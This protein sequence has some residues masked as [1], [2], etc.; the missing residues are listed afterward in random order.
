VLDQ[1]RAGAGATPNETVRELSVA[2][3]AGAQVTLAGPIDVLSCPN[4]AQERL[5]VDFEGATVLDRASVGARL[6]DGTLVFEVDALLA[7]ANIRAVDARRH[8]LR[9]KRTGST[10]NTAF[11]TADAVL[12]TVTLDFGLADEI[13]REIQTV[14]EL[15]Y[16]DPS[17]STL[18]RLGSLRSRLI[19]RGENTRAETLL[20][21]P[22]VNG[23]LFCVHQRAHD[24]CASGAARSKAEATLG[25]LGSVSA[26]SSVLSEVNSR[27]ADSLRVCPW[28]VFARGSAYAANVAT[29][30]D[31]QRAYTW[32]IFLSPGRWEGRTPTM[33]SFDAL[34]ETVAGRRV[35][36]SVKV[37]GA[38]PGFTGTIDDGELAG[39]Y[40]SRLQM[41]AYQRAALVP[42]SRITVNGGS[43]SGRFELYTYQEVFEGPIKTA[44]IDFAMTVPLPPVPSPTLCTHATLP[45]PGTD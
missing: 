33:F 22:W 32:S 26:G 9:V 6:L 19:A 42:T 34:D 23:Q 41:L 35:Y 43:V 16:L 10:C 11:G 21:D 38:G 39:L 25:L 2:T 1:A 17:D 28:P 14:K 36:G 8:R 18:T 45:K 4:A 44:T 40:G 20:N 27:A 3:R 13:T 15:M 7:A 31:Y 5:V 24:E 12:V 29:V 37:T 30:T